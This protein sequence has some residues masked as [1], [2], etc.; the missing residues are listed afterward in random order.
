MEKR[1]K[2]LVRQMVHEAMESMGGKATNMAV[3]DWILEHHPSTSPNSIQSQIIVCTVNHESR[4]HYPE[5]QKPRR[6]EGEYDFLYRPSPGKLE[7]YDHRIHG[8]WEIA[9]DRHGFLYVRRADGGQRSRSDEIFVGGGVVE[10]GQLRA[11]LARSLSTVEEG[12]ELYVDDIGNDGIEYHTD[13]GA[14]DLL[15]VNRSGDFIVIALKVERSPEQVS[16]LILGYMNW[17]KQYIA[18][19]RPVRGYV[20]GS[21]MTD[22]IRYALAH[23]DDIQLREYEINIAL[24]DVPKA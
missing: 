23:R 17:V 4:V 3:R 8:L 7:L 12:L 11:Y 24:R 22:T 20:I 14:I 16:G 10:E 18:G 2:P 19:P 1:A 9:Q 15:T 6:A 13:I 21:H 5:N